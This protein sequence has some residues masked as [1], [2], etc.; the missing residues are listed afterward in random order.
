M[1]QR[2]HI[3]AVVLMIIAIRSA[4]PIAAR[5]FT[6]IPTFPDTSATSVF[7]QEINPGILSVDIV[8][9]VYATVDSPAV[10]MNSVVFGFA[11]QTATGTFGTATQQ[12]Y[13]KNP[14]AADNGWVVSLAAASPTASWVSAGT[15]MDFNDPNTVGCE[16]GADDDTLRGQ[17]T[18]NPNAGVLVKGACVSCVVT[19][20]S[21]GSSAAFN[22]ET[23]GD[24]GNSITILTGA[25][26]SDD[27]GDWLLTGVAVSQKIPGEQPAGSDYSISLVLSIVAS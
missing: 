23:P 5:A 2:I 17:M 22:E 9:D 3:I 16:D 18:A 27:V 1:K 13:V 26:T 21:K 7:T 25:D 14:D 24:A 19:N 12:I 20:V 10:A 11:C 6:I 15:S 8:D 4:T